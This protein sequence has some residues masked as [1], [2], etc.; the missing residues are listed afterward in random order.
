MDLTGVGGI[1][2][3]SLTPFDEAGAIDAAALGA[4]LRH[5][6]ATPGVRALV[7]NGHAGEATSLDRAERQRVVA[8]ARG[9]ANGTVGV[10]AGVVADDTRGACDLARDAAEAGADALLLFPPAMFANG[11]DARPEMALCF[12]DAVARASGLPITL[13]QLSRASGLAYSPELL[14]RLCREVDAVIAVKEGSDVPALYE[15]NLRAVRD[16]GRAV[17]VLTTNNTWLFASLAYGADGI[18]SGVGSVA[19]P[20]L[21]DMF[22]A[23]RRG[24]LAAARRFNDRLLPL[25][26]VFYRRPGLDM[27]NRMKTA[28]HILGLLPNPAP[29]PPLLPIEPAEREEIRAALVE[30]G[31][32]SAATAAAA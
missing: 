25:T 11:A 30:S 8:A 10:V 21:A 29:R 17:T 5:L 32:L 27:H 14:A 12:T 28:L 3:A 19:S 31:M 20:I 2:P 1:W 16:C 6:A 13:F 18:L 23:V 9:A 26:Q 22:E 7:V 4:H 24:D 15:R